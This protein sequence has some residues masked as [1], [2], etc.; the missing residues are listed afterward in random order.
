MIRLQ[1]KEARV[2]VRDAPVIRA[3]CGGIRLLP[4]SGRWVVRGNDAVGGQGLQV[5]VA[6]GDVEGGH[7][8]GAVGG[9]AVVGDDGSE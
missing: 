8:D 4:S 3:F 5:G 9:E 2:E 7:G 1:Q 6:N